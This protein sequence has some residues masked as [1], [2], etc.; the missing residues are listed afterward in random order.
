MVNVPFFF[1]AE[2]SCQK[3]APQEEISK[4]PLQ[5][6]VS[7]F[8]SFGDKTI[9]TAFLTYWGTGQWGLVPVATWYEV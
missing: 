4:S 3:T 7:E 8:S 6:E 1:F 5:E 9:V 2:E